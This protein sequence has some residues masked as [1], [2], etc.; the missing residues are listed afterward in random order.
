MEPAP[1]AQGAD[2]ASA[3]E[4]ARAYVPTD[5]ENVVLGNCRTQSLIRG[6]TLAAAT[7]FVGSRGA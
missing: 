6:T 3:I 7:I 4:K 5:A 1:A 2:R